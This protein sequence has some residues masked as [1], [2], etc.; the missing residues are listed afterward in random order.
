[1]VWS[2]RGMIW[3]TLEK[4]KA[5]SG[6]LVVVGSRLHACTADV[7]RWCS[8]VAAVWSS[9]APA[10]EGIVERA[11]VFAAG[12]FACESSA[13]SGELIQR[14]IR[15]RSGLPIGSSSR[16]RM[17]ASGFRSPTNRSVFDKAGKEGPVDAVCVR[18]GPRKRDR[19]RS[20]KLKP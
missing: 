11:S 6:S 15:S 19:G 17:T 3:L 12:R 10:S 14:P 4:Y 5:V 1:M 13:L 8:T 16:S 7:Y 2:T 20:E 18:E 9:R